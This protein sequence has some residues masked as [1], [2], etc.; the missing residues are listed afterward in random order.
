MAVL[1]PIP[2]TLCWG[3][4][5]RWDG[6]AARFRVLAWAGVPRVLVGLRYQPAPLQGASDL[7][8]VDMS[9]GQSST[10]D[11]PRGEVRGLVIGSLR[12]RSWGPSGRRVQCEDIGF[13]N[14]TV[15]GTPAGVA[16]IPGG[17]RRPGV[18]HL[19]VQL[20]HSIHHWRPPKTQIMA[21]AAM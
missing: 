3:T 13:L 2:G 12:A 18:G 17:A 8:P 16:G 6:P 10:P 1:G 9:D 20:N 19:R 21:A 4:E 5:S 11:T 15:G 7:R 14:P